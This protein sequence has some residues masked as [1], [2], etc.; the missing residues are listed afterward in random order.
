MELFT[1]NISIIIPYKKCKCV[2]TLTIVFFSVDSWQ[3]TIVKRE[4]DVYNYICIFI[5]CFNKYQVMF[6]Q[7]FMVIE[8]WKRYYLDLK[9][10]NLQHISP[11]FKLVRIYGMYNSTQLKAKSI[12]YHTYIYTYTYI[13][14]M[15]FRN[16]GGRGH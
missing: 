6:Y 9:I 7:G 14:P 2:F 13:H 15:R 5:D 16:K 4:R 11:L 12:M 8:Q 3:K 10:K 1:L